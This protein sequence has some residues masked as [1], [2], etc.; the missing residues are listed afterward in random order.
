[1]APPNP[2]L[3]VAPAASVQTVLLGFLLLVQ[4]ALA[5][6]TSDVVL[7][8]NI[9]WKSI[10]FKTIL[11]WEPKPANFVYSVEISTR[12]GDWKKKCF[13]IKKT[14][15]DLTD[16]MKNVRETYVAR[17]LSEK[18]VKSDEDPE[19]PLHANA[20]YFTPYLDTNLGQPRI[21]SFEQNDAKLKVTVQDSIT[22]FRRDGTFQTL[23][24]IF[25]QDLN[26]TLYYWRASSTGKK[27]VNTDTNE[28]LVEVDK[29]E[30][31]C[32]NVQAVIPSRRAKQK[33]PESAIHCTSQDK[34]VFKELFFIV[35]AVLFVIIILVIILS[36]TLYKCS[37]AR[38]KRNRME[39]SPL[40]IA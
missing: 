23:R 14:E 4:V 27:S 21:Q 32:F 29:G 28:F 7:A 12:W 17:I 30:S 38:A 18:A 31:Y 2:C 10:D 20:P 8:H 40:N 19:E 35:G 16:E 25:H 39:N 13:Q 15:C 3:L 36:V 9:T 22:S 11:E 5:S 34:V 1:M 24:Q 33:S 37:K 26:Y 6:G